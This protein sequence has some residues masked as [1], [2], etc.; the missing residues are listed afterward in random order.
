[1]RSAA[2]ALVSLIA[3]VLVSGCTSKQNQEQMNTSNESPSYSPSY[4]FPSISLTVTQPPDD[5]TIMGQLYD[6]D[7]PVTPFSSEGFIQCGIVQNHTYIINGVTYWSNDEYPIFM[8]FGNNS[9]SAGHAFRSGDYKEALIRKDQPFWFR[10]EKWDNVTHVIIRYESNRQYSY[11]DQPII[12]NLA[13]DVH[14]VAHPY[15]PDASWL[16]GLRDNATKG[17]WYDFPGKYP[18]SHAPNI[19]SPGQI[20]PGE[21]S[22]NAIQYNEYGVPIG[23]LFNIGHGQ[24]P[25]INNSTVR[26]IGLQQFSPIGDD[27][28][29]EYRYNTIDGK[30]H[31]SNVSVS[32]RT[33]PMRLDIDGTLTQFY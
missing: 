5:I 2:I 25:P 13:T 27:Y 19:I 3:L 15:S 16:K 21:F 1:M 11:N 9:Y 22:D 33:S 4:I 31:T 6:A 10:F 30:T 23:M 18:D 24:S 20:F 17:L 29:Q 8:P 14:L 7:L 28:M 32:G 12:I 26:S